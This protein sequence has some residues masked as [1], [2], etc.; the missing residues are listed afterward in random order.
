MDMERRILSE[1]ERR[2]LRG[3][4]ERAGYLLGYAKEI[5]LCLSPPDIFERELALDPL[6]AGLYRT[7]ACVK[8]RAEL[9]EEAAVDMTRALLVCEDVDALL[10][11]A[12]YVRAVVRLNSVPPWVNAALESV[13]HRLDGTRASEWRHLVAARVG[14]DDVAVLVRMAQLRRGEGSTLEVSTLGSVLERAPEWL[15]GWL[16]MVVAQSRTGDEVAA[17]RAL[18]RL[19]TLESRGRVA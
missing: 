11:E 7:R 17:Y 19:Q 13:A 16:R 4:V 1:I 2:A 5:G 12:R 8:H 10:E 3:E 18:E 14:S 6:A 15:E 9:R